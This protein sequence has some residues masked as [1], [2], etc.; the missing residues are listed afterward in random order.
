MT[1]RRPSPELEARLA[2]VRAAKARIQDKHLMW[3]ID[4]ALEHYVSEAKRVETEIVRYQ[5]LADLPLFSSSGASVR[6]R[7]LRRGRRSYRGCAATLT[8]ITRSSSSCRRSRMP[9]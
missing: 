3:I 5:T 7:P 1:T 9:R 2:A 6:S 4:A 8:T